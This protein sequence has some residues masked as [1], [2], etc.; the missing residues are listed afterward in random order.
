MAQQNAINNRASTF[1]VDSLLTVTAGGA[2]VTSGNITATSGNVV[3]TSGLIT[4]P[5]STST[6][7]QVQIDGFRFLYGATARTE[8]FVGRAAGNHTVTGTGTVGVGYTALTNLTSGTNNTVVGGSAGITITSGGTN[9]AIGSA[10][11]SSGTL[12]GSGNVAIGYQGGVAWT[13]S[14]AN[15]VSIGSA[16]VVGESNVLHIGDTT[17]TGARGLNKAFI[18]GIF[19]ITVGVSGIP[20]VVDNANQ[21]GTVVSSLRFKDNIKDMGND[22]SPVMKLRPVSFNYK[23]HVE[24]SYGLIAEE[25]EKV[26]PDLVVYDQS[27]QAMAVKYHDLPAF[28][29]NEIQRLVKRI[30]VLEDKHGR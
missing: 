5:T 2:T 27:R 12:T 9:T 22:S 30:E 16:G 28:L 13:T 4:L 23:G 18:C 1:T 6:V 29:L 21:L 25:V 8:T 20:V 3:V 11:M 26:M 19:G 7:G 10:S 14:E 17:G 24:R 15:N